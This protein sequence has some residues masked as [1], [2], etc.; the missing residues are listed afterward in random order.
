MSAEQAAGSLDQEVTYDTLLRGRVK[1]VQP[2]RGFR[3]SLDPVLLGSFVETPCG[4]FLD[5]GCGTGALAFVVLARDPRAT[6]MGIEIQPRLAQLAAQGARAN[7][8]TGRF[9][10][11]TGDARAP[12]VVPTGAFD[13]VIT[14]PPFRLVGSGVLPTND[15]RRTAN[16]EVSLTLTQWLDVATAAAAPGGRLAVIYAANRTAELRAGLTAHGWVLRRLRAVV[17]RTGE[18]AR[19]VLIE[20]DRRLADRSCQEEAPLVVHGNGTYAPE[21]RR[22]LGE[23]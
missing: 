8:F 5:I 16:H 2:S 1:L 14:N 18:M 9:E 23:E 15:E 13:L 3:A 10:V 7:E 22:M 11:R 21:V 20:A 6:G 19:R 12:G 17:S 4:R